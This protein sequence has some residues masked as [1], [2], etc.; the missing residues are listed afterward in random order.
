MFLLP[1]LAA[2]AF[3]PLIK[4][5]GDAAAKGDWN[6]VWTMTTSF[7]DKS[8]NAEQSGSFSVPFISEW[9]ATPLTFTTIF[10]IWTFAIVFRNVLDIVRAWIDANLEQRLLVGFRQRLYEHL[11]SL[12]LDFFS[13][14][15][16]GALMQRVLSETTSVQRLL[17]QVILTPLVDAVVLVIVVTYLLTLS[18]QMTLVLFITAPLTVLMFKFTSAKLQEGALGI[19]LSAREL[20]SELEETINGISDIQV[21]NAQPKRNA[22]FWEA[23]KKAAKSFSLNDRLDESE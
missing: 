21:F 6:N 2:A 7:Y 4:L 18:W 10:I 13:G 1:F 22:R 20:G 15:Q 19:N 8:A 17:T 23:S 3:G 9:L 11:Q 14:G 5:F 16:T 12:S